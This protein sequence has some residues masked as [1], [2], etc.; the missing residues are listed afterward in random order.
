MDDELEQW[1]A[2]ALK[3][4]EEVA[5]CHAR[6]E[7]DHH[8]IMD[9]TA[10]DG[11]R[12]VKIPYDERADQ[13]DGIEARDETIRLQDEQI[14]MLLDSAAKDK[15]ELVKLRNLK[16]M[17]DASSHIKEALFAIPRR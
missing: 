9:D 1:K 15:A 17:L 4:E 12:R 7:I 2:R 13:I 3:A 11:L 16:S 14:D 10:D 5:R 6:L 8:Y